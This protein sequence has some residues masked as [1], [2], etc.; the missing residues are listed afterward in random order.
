MLVRGGACSAVASASLTLLTLCLSLPEA[1]PSQRTAL[2]TRA[3]AAAAA[4]AATAA[5]RS[6]FLLSARPHSS[7]GDRPQRRPPSSPFPIPPPPKA[8]ED[9][10][11]LASRARV[12]ADVNSHRPREYWDYESHVVEWGNQVGSLKCLHF[13]YSWA[14][15][16]MTLNNKLCK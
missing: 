9:T 8:D 3:A 13:E 14:T 1:A 7:G 4:A 2:L 12:Y 10:M 5:G 15:H 6:P 16:V 11:P